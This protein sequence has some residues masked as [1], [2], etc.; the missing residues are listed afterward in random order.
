MDPNELKPPD[1]AGAGVQPQSFPAQDAVGLLKSYG[2]LPAGLLQQPQANPYAAAISAGMPFVGLPD[3]VARQQQQARIGQNQGFEQAMQMKAM[4]QRNEEKA[5]RRQQDQLTVYQHFL[6]SDNDAA[7]AFGAQG[8][9]STL[10]QMGMPVP[11]A[12]LEG[13]ATKTLSVK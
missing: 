13:L 5:Y 11:Q 4:Q 7:R 1:M 6:E 2:S 10:K 9:G 8:V 12:V 3:Q